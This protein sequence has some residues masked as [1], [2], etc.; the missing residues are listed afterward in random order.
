[1]DDTKA[2]ATRNS[3]A[4]RSRRA[5]RVIACGLGASLLMAGLAHADSAISTV[6]FADIGILEKLGLANEKAL[7]ATLIIGLSAVAA[8]LW[9]RSFSGVVKT[10]HTIARH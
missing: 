5:R 9:H 2:P 8:G 3:T 6:A 10:K 7:F 1:M 4:S